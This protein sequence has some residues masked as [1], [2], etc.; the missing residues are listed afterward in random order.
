LKDSGGIRAI[1]YHAELHIV[2]RLMRQQ[3]YPKGDSSSNGS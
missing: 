2:Y 1:L 3:C